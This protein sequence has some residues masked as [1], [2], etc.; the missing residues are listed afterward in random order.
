MFFYINYIILIFFGAWLGGVA[1]TLYNR[2]P[3]NIPIGPEHKPKCN[4]CN[5]I[6]K[7]LYFLPILGYFISKGKCISCKVKIPVKYL[8][9]ETISTV[10]I[11]ILY[12]KKYNCFS[13][14]F[15]IDSILVTYILL[16]IF[17]NISFKK[18][19]LLSNLIFLILIQMDL[20]FH[21]NH[22]TII[23]LAYSIL[24]SYFTLKLIN[25][26]YTIEMKDFIV[27][28]SSLTFIN[29]YEVLLLAYMPYICALY[30]MPKIP[31]LLKN[32]NFIFIIL[33]ISCL[34]KI[35]Q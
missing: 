1:T 22:L 11:I 20:I 33:L 32:L 5:S 14:K 4:S 24:V 16:M 7:T 19:P 26:K 18:L 10:A 23:F 35:F 9:L 28:V 30:F 3:N 27:I 17:I 8:L 21:K 15:I 12:S 2:I 13:D 29:S 25:K 31:K 34:V 6:I